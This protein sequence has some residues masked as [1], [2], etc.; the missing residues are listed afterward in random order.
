MTEAL[1]GP[2]NALQNFQKHTTVDRTLQQDRTLLRRPAE[3]GFRS[4]SSFVP[5]Q[6]DAE[7][8]AFQAPK[9]LNGFQNSH[10]SP[11]PQLAA[12]PQQTL[13]NW[14]SDFQRL[15]LQSSGSLIPQRNLQPAQ[16]PFTASNGWHT[17][18]ATQRDDQAQSNFRRPGPQYMPSIQSPYQDIQPFMGNIG[19]SLPLA[20]Q[21]LPG[22][23]NHQELHFD[24]A[25]FEQAF[26]AASAIM[27]SKSESKGKERVNNEGQSKFSMGF[28][29][30]DY[31]DVTGSYDYDET[32]EKDSQLNGL[33]VKN[34]TSVFADSQLT[35]DERMIGES[36]QQPE[37][38]GL[39]DIPSAADTERI[40]SDT[41][42]QRTEEPNFSPEAEADELSRTAGQLIETLK[43]EQSDKFKQSNFL[44]L[45][46][47]LRDKEVR[48]EG[49]QMVSVSTE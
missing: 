48:V 38:M 19:H 27:E 30:T 24:E 15:N 28:A 22:N 10:S 42:P 34:A 18:F 35:N 46:R 25:A 20:Q 26:D 3:Q 33:G 11:L 9:A 2:S 39:H 32:I 45:M 29:C 6:L 8:E 47:Q 13:P 43:S 17:E 31:G 37:D 41:I 23:V 36:W 5:G 4:T 16:S 44:Q 1:C 12:F 14:A 40:G 21:A 49:D 7:F